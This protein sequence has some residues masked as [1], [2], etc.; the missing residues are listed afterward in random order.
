[1]KHFKW[2]SEV[3]EHFDFNLYIGTS[4][5]ISDALIKN[6][7]NELSPNADAK[8]TGDENLKASFYFVTD[9]GEIEPWVISHEAGHCLTY[10]YWNLEMELDRVNDHAHIYFH[11]WIVKSIITRMRKYFE[12]LESKS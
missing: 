5:E 7:F 10:V 6:G 2:K 1:M 12:I 9:R 11:D 4:E 8:F 3:Y